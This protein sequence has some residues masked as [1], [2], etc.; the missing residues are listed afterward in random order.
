MVTAKKNGKWGMI[1][2]L[3]K[4]IIP[5]E[6][7]ELSFTDYEVLLA[8]KNGKMGVVGLPNK[9][10]IPFEYEELSFTEDEVLLA[11]KNGKLGIIDKKNKALTSFFADSFSYGG[12]TTVFFQFPSDESEDISTK[13]GISWESGAISNSFILH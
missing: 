3:N 12:G 10:I 13:H 6:Y 5:F 9:I 7:E 4:I 11:K 8:K 2:K 1:G